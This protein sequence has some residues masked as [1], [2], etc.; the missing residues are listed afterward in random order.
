MVKKIIYV[1]IT[2]TIFIVLIE[3][4]LKVLGFKSYKVPEYS[5]ISTPKYCFSSSSNYGIN[6]LPGKFEININNGLIHTVTHNN[7]S[8]RIC[9]YTQIDSIQNEIFIFGC[10]YTYGTGIND[11]ETYPFLL[12]NEFSNTKI[13]N[14]AVPSYGT[15][16]A[17]LELKKQID[18]QHIPNIVIIGFATFHEERNQMNKTYQY[19]LIQGVEINKINVNQL[20]FPY[21]NLQDNNIG[22][23]NVIKKFKAIPLRKHL[24]LA[25]LIENIDLNI[26]S[27]KLEKLTYSKEL[28]L[29]IK[30][31]CRQHNIK[32]IIADIDYSEDSKKIAS[33]CKTQKINYLN[34]SP[35]FN[36]E[37]YRNSPYDPHP[38]KEAHQIYFKKMYDYLKSA[39][40]GD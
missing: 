14:Y 3:L 27:K 17:L 38:N 20:I 34:I 4:S 15:T 40:F 13:T 2:L 16:H 10:S 22:Y 25:N 37:G 7:D 35:D 39:N 21:L 11:S 30:E 32:L 8:N 26:Q 1:V 24:A 19:K 18:N 33:F 28:I 9:S 6:L 23:I 36:K 31:L 29:E 5:F 12:Q